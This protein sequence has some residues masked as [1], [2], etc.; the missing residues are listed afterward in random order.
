[1]VFFVVAEDTNMYFQFRIQNI[2]KWCRFTEQALMVLK[3]IE[4]SDLKLKENIN[5][6]DMN[7]NEDNKPSNY[8][9]FVSNNSICQ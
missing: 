3:L 6:T 8:Y 9:G 2:W 1:M 4:T 5:S 7:N